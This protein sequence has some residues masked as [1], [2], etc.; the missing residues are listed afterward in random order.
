MA[1]S[2][3]QIDYST[4]T[5]AELRQARGAIDADAFPI[6][7]KN[8]CDAIDAHPQKEIL[9]AK[10]PDPSETPEQGIPL[11]PHGFIQI[12]MKKQ[13][14]PFFR[15]VMICLAILVAREFYETLTSEV[16]YSRKIEFQKGD[17]WGYYMVLIR[18]LVLALFF[19]WLAT[20][21]VAERDDDK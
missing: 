17:H 5:I 12:K 20:F 2:D 8:L 1:D 11:G 18:D 16:A 21:G 7:F 19:A 13:Y 15:I 9:A 6:N 14:V 3:G 4:Y 10:T